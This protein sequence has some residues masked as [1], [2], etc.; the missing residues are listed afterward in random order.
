MGTDLIIFL[1][2]RHKIFISKSVTIPCK[3]DKKSVRLS[4]TLT[5]KSAKIITKWSDLC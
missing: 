4:S 5:I 2:T 1:Q 3:L